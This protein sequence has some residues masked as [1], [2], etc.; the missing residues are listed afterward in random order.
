[1]RNGLLRFELTPE[2][3]GV[4]EF[5]RTSCYGVGVDLCMGDLIDGLEDAHPDRELEMIFYPTRSP[6]FFF[7]KGDISDVDVKGVLF[8]FVRGLRPGRKKQVM[9]A[10]IDLKAQAELNMRNGTLRG[11]I[12]M[13]DFKMTLR[14]SNIPGITRKSVSELGPMAGDIIEMLTNNMLGEG[15]PMPSLSGAKLVKPEMK[16]MERVVRLET[17]LWIDPQTIAEFTRKSI[18]NMNG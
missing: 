12:R 16:I 17:D 4:G 6:A 9:A 8:L 2:S 5:L 10:Q 13:K 18:T 7:R 11:N 14:R 15:L 3:E 1:M